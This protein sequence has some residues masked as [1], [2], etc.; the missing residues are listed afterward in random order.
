MTLEAAEPV[1]PAGPAITRNGLDI[2]N[3]VFCLVLGGILVARRAAILSDRLH[4][5]EDELLHVAAFAADGPRRQ[6]SP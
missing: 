2:I 5:I 4:L 6:S 3:S 1:G